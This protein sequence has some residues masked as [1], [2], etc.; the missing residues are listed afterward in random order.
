MLWLTDLVPK[1][2]AG[3]VDTDSVSTSKKSIS[4]RRSKSH[5]HMNISSELLEIEEQLHPMLGVIFIDCPHTFTMDI[6]GRFLLW[7]IKALRRNDHQEAYLVE[8]ATWDA[9]NATAVVTAA[10]KSGKVELGLEEEEEDANAAADTPSVKMERQQDENIRNVSKFTSC[11][12]R[13]MCKLL[14][15]VES[16]QP[17]DILHKRNYE[18]LTDMLRSFVLLGKEEEDVLLALGGELCV[19]CFNCVYDYNMYVCLSFFLYS[20]V[21][22][23]M[24]ACMFL[25]L[26][27][28]S[29]LTNP[30]L[31]FVYVCVC[32]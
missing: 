17:G 4:S 11:V 26:F 31:F 16:Y 1:T 8:D 28:A 24:S 9:G 2:A 19:S 22:A 13:V 27:Y 6:F 10:A 3:G 12:T 15:L 29:F 5:Q 7:C 32:N 25:W 20:C 21:F 30:L 14:M 23:C 18:V